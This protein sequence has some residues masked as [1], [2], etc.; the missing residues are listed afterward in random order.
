[1]PGISATVI[2]HCL[3]ANPMHKPVVQKK[4]HMGPERAAAANTEV[5]KLLEAVFIREC[6]YPEWI[7]NVI[8]VKKPN[9]TWRMCVDFTDLNKACSKDSYPL[10]KID[11]LVDATAGHALVSFMD[12]FSGY[13]Q[14][15][16]CPEDQEKTAFITD[17][18]LHCYKVM[19]FGLKNVGV[20]YQ[21]LVNKLFEPLI[22]RTMEVY[23]DNMK[24]Y[25]DDMIIK[26]KLQSDH[27][28]NLRQTFEVLRT[29]NIKLN[30][31]KCVF[32]VRSSKFLGFMI[33]HRNIEAN[34]DKIQ[35]ILD[36]QPPRTIR[37]VQR[38]TG[39]RAALR[40]FMSRSADKC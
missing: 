39:C 36:M 10:P 7:S 21:R 2:E 28:G 31:K 8:L 9:G 40:C 35:A 26:S 17:R 22:R 4:R 5:Q 34:P 19:P 13:H 30:P 18:G 1:M 11:K 33:S 20:T 23:V 15:P 27:K 3:N 6:Q 32:G 24:V 38:L 25:V 37:E 14:I 12:A 16:L 29:F